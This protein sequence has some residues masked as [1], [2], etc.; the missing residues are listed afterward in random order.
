MMI[1]NNTDIEFIDFIDLINT[2]LSNE[3]VERWRFRFSI[4]FIKHF[5]LKILQKQKVL[6]LLQLCL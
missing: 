6:H 2:T 1:D 3:F 5:Q 4:K